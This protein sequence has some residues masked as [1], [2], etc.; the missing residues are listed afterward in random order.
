VASIVGF[1]TLFGIATRSGVLL[2]S[3]CQHLMRDEELPLLAAVRRG[4]RERLAPC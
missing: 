3:H 2:V 4:S 1:V